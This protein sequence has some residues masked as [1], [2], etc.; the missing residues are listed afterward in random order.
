MLAAFFPSQK[1]PY[2][3]TQHKIALIINYTDFPIINYAGGQTLLHDLKESLHKKFGEY[4]I[5][6]NESL[7]LDYLAGVDGLR[8]SLLQVSSFSIVFN[9]LI[10][11]A[12]SLVMIL[13]GA[14]FFEKSE[15]V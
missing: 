6:E 11:G 1:S 12:F 15:S 8:A 5:K 2:S 13:L 10:L 3:L 4:S 7:H 9:F 14:Y